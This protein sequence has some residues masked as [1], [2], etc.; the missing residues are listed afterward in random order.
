MRISALVPTHRST[1]RLLA[2]AALLLAT[3]VVSPAGAAPVLDM[4][5]GGEHNCTL[6][7]CGTIYCYGGPNNTFGEDANATGS[8]DDLAVGID[9][10]CGL[11]LH[12]DSDPAGGGNVTCWGRT[13]ATGGEPPGWDL[14]D[15]PEGDY[16][17]IDAGGF[18]TCGVRT[19]HTLE[20]WGW[21]RH[22]EATDEPTNHYAQVS[23]G[24]EYACG[25]TS[26]FSQIECWGD[27]PAGV[28]KFHIRN[29][30]LGMANEEWVKV[31]AGPDHVCALAKASTLQGSVRQRIYCWGQNAAGQVTPEH[32]D[33]PDYLAAEELTLQ[34]NEDQ[35]V[36][37]YR[38]Y[39]DD[40]IDVATGGVGTCAVRSD[41]PAD[42]NAQREIRC[43]GYPFTPYGAGLASW[44][45]P[46][47]LP[48][49]QN[50][51][52][53]RVFLAYPNLCAIDDTANEVECWSVPYP[54]ELG[55]VDTD[56]YTCMP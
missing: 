28:T 26:G 2:P 49:L 48:P 38:H 54:D 40:Y 18:L 27:V 8:F 33:Y 15:V 20:C 3:A 47:D 24:Y 16:I 43:W 22:N 30:G 51:N 41:D 56:I 31:A 39:G 19:D 7:D 9:H 53:H 55:E 37:I 32:P 11:T 5:V 17:Q 6:N 23:V 45:D 50:I 13:P 10:T 52:P 42:D 44:G 21:N 35:S 34:L 46:S 25:V 4:D 12:D 1:H 14:L 36:K 29:S